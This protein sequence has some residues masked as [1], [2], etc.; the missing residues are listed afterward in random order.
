METVCFQMLWSLGRF[1]VFSE[2][3]K[4]IEDEPCSGEKL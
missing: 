3:R 1:K 2:G 4:L